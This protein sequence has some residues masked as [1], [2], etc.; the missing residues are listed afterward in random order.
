MR[1][2]AVFTV[3]G[4]VLAAAI[5]FL[6]I[7]RTDKREKHSVERNG[8]AAMTDHIEKELIEWKPD[9]EDLGPTI[10]H[11][12]QPKVN[13]VGEWTTEDEPAKSSI[14][15]E[16]NASG[17]Y[18]IDF[19]TRG[20]LSGWSLHREGVYANAILR[21]NKSIEEYPSDIYDTLYAVSVNGSDYLI[22]QS[23]IRFLI[24]HCSKDEGADWS[25]QIKSNAFHRAVKSEEQSRRP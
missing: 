3:A 9:H 13:V 6:P 1:K 7:R 16:K 2:V 25:E 24:K 10:A 14:S 22:S 5:C 15:I 12:V 21:L 23:A 8:E 18:V 20:C 4:V 11:F 19:S 17:R